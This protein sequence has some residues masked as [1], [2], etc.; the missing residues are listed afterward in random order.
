MTTRTATRQPTGKSGGPAG[1]QR[2]WPVPAALIA[3]VTI[4]VRQSREA[5]GE[6]PV[7]VGMLAECVDRGE[8]GAQAL[9]VVGEERRCLVNRLLFE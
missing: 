3:L 2:S 7:G 8:D 4:P 1:S 6:G 9:G 5:E